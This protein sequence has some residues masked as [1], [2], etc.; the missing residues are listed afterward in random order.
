MLRTHNIASR[1][2]WSLF[3]NI[4]IRGKGRET[5][6]CPNSSFSHNVCHWLQYDMLGNVKQILGDWSNFSEIFKKDKTYD[7]IKSHK[8]HGFPLSLENESAKLTPPCY[9]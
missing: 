3:L 4:V 6:S 9:I 7:N 5:Q 2:F 8:K 1:K